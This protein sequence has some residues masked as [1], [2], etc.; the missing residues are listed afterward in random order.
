MKILTAAQMQRIDRLTTERYG[1]PSLTLME[2]AGQRVV[3]FLSEHYAPLDQQR[4]TILCGRGNNGGDGLVAARLLR[5]LGLSPRVLLFAD[6]QSVRGDAATNLER[7]IKHWPISW[8]RTLE[9]WKALRREIEG[10]T[11]FV[12]AM[13]GTG[14]SKP[15][16]G[17][18]L[19]VVQDL[20][21]R[22]SSVKAVAV[23]L[24]TGLSADSGHLIGECLRAD[25]SV[26]FTALKH[27]HVF[28]PACEWAGKVRVEGIGT[29]E[30][31]LEGDPGLFLDLTEP[32]SLSWLKQPRPLDAHK[33]TFGHVLVIAGSVGK[34]GAAAMAAKAALRAGAGL[35]TVLTPRSAL[36]TLSCL[37]LEFMTEPLPETADGTVSLHALHGGAFGKVLEGKTVLAIGPGLGNNPDTAEFV[38]T[39]VDKVDLPIVLDADGLNAFAGHAD[40]LQPRSRI[41]ILTP[42]PGEMSRLAGLETREVLERRIQ[43]ARDFARARQVVLVLKG[44]RTLI[45]SPNGR[46]SVNPTGNPGMATGG[47]GDCLTGLA[48]GLLAAFRSQPADAV[49][50]AAVYVHGLA[51]DIAAGKQ[52][53]VSMVAG[54][55]LDAIPEAFRRCCDGL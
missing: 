5:A 17:V 38:R 13:L 36:P 47:T 45:A 10:T 37:G 44:S 4:I 32:Q 21:A 26:T 48:A 12:D 42:H 7:Y 31:L 41:R 29:P 20:N 54:D 6:P 8:V 35:V 23:D 40:Q 50:A 15:V 43:V 1:I 39:V 49:A 28:P 24:P 30:E 46:V 11:L 27:A 18:L 3:E 34:T 52:G 25:A 2:N 22:G 19:E 9:D 14:L 16:E 55:L 53:Q 33:G 51:G